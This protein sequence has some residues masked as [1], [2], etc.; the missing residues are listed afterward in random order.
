MSRGWSIS[1]ARRHL[2]AAINSIAEVDES[3]TDGNH[4]NLSAA[5]DHI[6]AAI[7]RLPDWT[8]NFQERHGYGNE[9]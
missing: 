8:P 1:E 5:T 3:D 4:G 2:Q 7:H 9:G 6:E